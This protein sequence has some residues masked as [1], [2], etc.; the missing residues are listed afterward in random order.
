MGNNQNELKFLGNLSYFAE[1]K[2]VTQVEADNTSLSA[3]LRLL[4][5]AIKTVEGIIEIERAK[6]A[7]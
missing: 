1:E 7:L 5:N 2:Y 3:G 6:G 4:E